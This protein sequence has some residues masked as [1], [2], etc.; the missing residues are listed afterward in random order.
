MPSLGY[1]TSLTYGDFSSALCFHAYSEGLGSAL[2]EPA[3]IRA[4]DCLDGILEETQF[5]GI[6]RVLCGEDGGAHDDV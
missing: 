6:G 4:W 5:L 2:G 1:I 3:I